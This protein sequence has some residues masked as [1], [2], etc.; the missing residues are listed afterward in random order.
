M[1]GRVATSLVSTELEGIILTRALQET[2]GAW[3]SLPEF[4]TLVGFTKQRF[5]IGR[6]LPTAPSKAAVKSKIIVTV[7][8]TL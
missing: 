6:W 3:D 4:C 8:R 5:R 1:S 2:F 7:S